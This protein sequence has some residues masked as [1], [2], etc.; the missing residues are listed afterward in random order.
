M[1]K[2]ILRNGVS[3]SGNVLPAE[4]EIE[5]SDEFV[6]QYQ[7]SGVIAKIIEQKSSDIQSNQIKK[8]GKK[9]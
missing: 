9:K 5:V 2:I 6:A 1:P 8:E 7:D 3:V 4:T